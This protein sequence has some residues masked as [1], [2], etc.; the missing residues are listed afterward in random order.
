MIRYLPFL[1]LLFSVVHA[2]PVQV[3]HHSTLETASSAQSDIFAVRLNGQ[4]VNVHRMT[5][6]RVET[7]QGAGTTGQHH[8]VHFSMRGPV[9]IEVDFLHAESPTSYWVRPRVFKVQHSRVNDTVS[10]R[11]HFPHYYVLRTSHNNVHHELYLLADPLFENAP[12]PTDPNVLRATDLTGLRNDGSVLSSSDFSAAQRMIQQ[13]PDKDILYLDP[14]LF[15]FGGGSVSHRSGTG[16][17]LAGGSYLNSKRFG[18]NWQEG[19][20]LRGRGVLDTGND[21]TEGEFNG[22]L[23]EIKYSRNFALEGIIARHSSD[24]HIVSRLSDDVYITHTKVLGSWNWVNND[25][26]N[27]DRARRVTVDKAF[28][29]TSADNNSDK[30]NAK[31]TD[32]G[33]QFERTVKDIYRNDIVTYSDAK[34]QKFGTETDADYF[35]DILFEN[36]FTVNNSGPR[37]HIADKATFRNIRF[38]NWHVDGGVASDIIVSGWAG[39]NPTTGNVNGMSFEDVYVYG[40]GKA[41]FRGYSP[42]NLVQNVDITNLY[43]GS[44]GFASSTSDLDGME[45]TANF[46]FSTKASVWAAHDRYGLVNEAVPLNGYAYHDTA[47]WTQISGPAPAQFA[48]SSDP[49]SEVTFS[50]RGEYVLRITADNSPGE[51]DELT[52]T[53][54]DPSFLGEPSARFIMLPTFPV[55]NQSITFDGSYSSDPDGSLVRYDWDFGDGTLLNDAGPTPTHSYSST[56]RFHI[57]LTVTDNDGNTRTV[58]DFILVRRGATPHGGSAHSVPG[59]VQAEDYDLGVPGLTY[60]DRSE[61]DGGDDFNGAAI[62][63]VYRPIDRFVEEYNRTPAPDIFASTDA[64]DSNGFELGDIDPGNGSTEWVSYTLNVASAGTYDLSFRVNPNA[65]TDRFFSIYVNGVKQVDRAKW[66]RSQNYIT[67]TISGVS[68]PSSGEHVLRIE[69]E[70]DIGS[71][72]Y[73]DFV[74]TGAP[75]P[76]SCFDR[77]PANGPAPLEVTVNAACSD[78]GGNNITSYRWDFGD[79]TILENGSASETHTYTTEGNYNITLTVT[80]ESLNSDQSSQ[81]VF[82]G[83]LDPTASFIY[84]PI[85]P[86]VNEAV[87]FDA[88]ASSDDDGSIVRY[89]WDFGDGTQQNNGGATPSHTFSSGG[90]FQV[91][92]TV[93]DNLG[94][95]KTLIVPITV[96]DPNNSASQSWDF[97]AGSGNRSFAEM[98]WVAYASHRD[99]NSNFTDR[100]GTG[101]FPALIKEDNQIGGASLALLDADG[102]SNAEAAQFYAGTVVSVPLADAISFRFKHISSTGSSDGTKFLRIAIQLDS[103]SWYLA[104]DPIAESPASV[105]TATLMF[106]DARWIAWE[107][108]SNGFSNAFSEATSGGISLNSGTIHRIG[109]VMASGRNSDFLLFDDVELL[110]S[111]LPPPT[112]P[113]INMDLQGADPELR[114]PSQSGYLYRLRGTDEL[115]S[116]PS[117]WPV[118]GEAK[119]GD[120]SV[121][122]FDLEDPATLPADAKR[123]YAIEVYTE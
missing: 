119:S 84:S 52:V 87:I 21:F 90:T 86:D 32:T 71:L 14:G 54:L 83:N 38:R 25:G 80:N 7:H 116:A 26:I 35:E 98:G 109:I 27:T 53:V 118:I 55:L 76:T 15:N 97:E 100:S 123:F 10:F 56:G 17:F 72:N 40:G 44:D 64:N 113:E 120:G 16:V 88:S 18:S 5:G 121:L 29:S 51:F 48:D 94:A 23:M 57:S 8:Y 46:S 59:R 114:V 110:T 93:T 117:T 106:A 43:L 50:S 45:H 66:T 9:D 69:F 24:W 47:T 75:V 96:I 103:G 112:A 28:I 73:I 62:S 105:S 67:Q 82:V 99:N 37:A 19:F 70:S 20:W 39:R 95:S 4:A 122:V 41:N 78:G 30:A 115:G 107:D 74:Q 85:T 60:R 77:T 36:F 65:N 34:G 101:A 111:A 42:S 79:G 89:D 2:Q 58:R 92:L 91:S 1:L 3:E 6:Y 104:E 12:Q 63:E 61:G 13:D 33:Y 68:F 11:L 22:K 81:G 102:A 108:P 31:D 49:E